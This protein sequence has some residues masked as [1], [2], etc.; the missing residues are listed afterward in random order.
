MNTLSFNYTF[1]LNLCIAPTYI[2]RLPDFPLESF[3]YMSVFGAEAFNGSIKTN[4]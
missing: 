3:S 4:G 1:I 2:L